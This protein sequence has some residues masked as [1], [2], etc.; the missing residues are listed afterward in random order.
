MSFPTKKPQLGRKSAVLTPEK[1]DFRPILL[2]HCISEH[3]S[4]TFVPLSRF[5]SLFILL[6]EINYEKAH[7]SIGSIYI[8]HSSDS[9]SIIH[10]VADG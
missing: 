10:Y 9:R 5:R 1:V 4:I 8:G 3:D 2:L 7:F 6:G